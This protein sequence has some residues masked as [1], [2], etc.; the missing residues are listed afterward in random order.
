MRIGRKRNEGNTV[1]GAFHAND[2]VWHDLLEGDAFVIDKS[3][4]LIVRASL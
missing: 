4:T 3:I 2:A 1:G